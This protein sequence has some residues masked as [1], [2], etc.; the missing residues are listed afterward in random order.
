MDNVDIQLQQEFSGNWTTMR[1][2][3]NIPLSILQ[4]M[5]EVKERFPNQAVRAMCNGMM[6]NILP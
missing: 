5:K 4:A 3:A 1:R 6:V 2:V